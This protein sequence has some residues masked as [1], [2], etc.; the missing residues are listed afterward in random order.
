MWRAR[1]RA[2]PHLQHVEVVAILRLLEEREAE[3]GR[4]RALVADAAE[5]RAEDGREALVP[6]QEEAVAHDDQRDGRE[7]RD[8]HAEE[9]GDVVLRS[10]RVWRRAGA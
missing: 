10:E 4:G 9:L 2:R 8:L 3:R 5:R 7:E 1:A 6:A